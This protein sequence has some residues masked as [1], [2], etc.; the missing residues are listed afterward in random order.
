MH[1]R[2][3]SPSSWQQPWSMTLQVHIVVLRAP[4]RPPWLPVRRMALPPS[5]RKS[6]S[7]H[8]Q[9]LKIG[10]GATAHQPQPQ[11]PAPP[12]SLWQVLGAA[13][14]A[15]NVMCTR[16]SRRRCRADIEPSDVLCL[17]PLDEKG[18]L[19]LA[20]WRQTRSS[21]GLGSRGRLVITCCHYVTHRLSAPLDCG[22]Y[23]R[24]CLEPGVS[25][26]IVC[27]KTVG[28]VGT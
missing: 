12:V 27:L 9:T 20:W 21:C 2:R 19:Y 11:P 4:R 23:S 5:S 26:L 17:T 15:C 8:V 28:A 24:K 14:C 3:S 7:L 13:A 18:A 1:D 25:V 6:N 22:C 16:R 10:C